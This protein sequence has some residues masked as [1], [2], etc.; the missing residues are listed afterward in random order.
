MNKP[1]AHELPTEEFAPEILHNLHAFD[2]LEGK[3]RVH[4]RRLVGRLSN[5]QEWVEFE[6]TNE[7][8]L[9]LNGFAN[10]DEFRTDYWPNFIGM[11]FRFFDPKKNRWSI[12]WMDTINRKLDTPVVGMFVGSTGTFFTEEEFEG[13]PIIVRFIWS[14]THT[15]TPRWEQAFSPDGGRT[16]ETNWS[17]NFTREK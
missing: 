3:Y 8:R 1:A 14:R 4:N 17:M 13:K 6:A 12:Y 5:S 16:W 2:F 9:L 11:T 15:P 10:Q 7:A